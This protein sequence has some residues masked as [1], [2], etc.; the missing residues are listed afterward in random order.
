MFRD[1]VLGHIRIGSQPFGGTELKQTCD[2]D[3]SSGKKNWDKI[4]YI[5]KYASNLMTTAKKNPVLLSSTPNVVSKAQTKEFANLEKQAIQQGN[6]AKTK[7]AGASSALFGGVFAPKTPTVPLEELEQRRTLDEQMEVANDFA[8]L[9]DE[10]VDLDEVGDDTVKVSLG[11]PYVKEN[12]KRVR[13]SNLHET[14]PH[15]VAQC[16]NMVVSPTELEL[17][18]SLALLPDTFNSGT[19]PTKFKFSIVGQVIQQIKVLIGNHSNRNMQL[20]LEANQKSPNKANIL[21]NFANLQIFYFVVNADW[22]VSFYGIPVSSVYGYTQ[23]DR[24]ALI[25]SD[26]DASLWMVSGLHVYFTPEAISNIAGIDIQICKW[27]AYN[28][29]VC[30]FATMTD[31][32]NWTK[33]FEDE[34]AAKKIF[35]EIRVDAVTAMLAYSEKPIMLHPIHQTYMIDQN[36]GFKYVAKEQARVWDT[37]C[38]ARPYLGDKV[39]NVVM[40]VAPGIG[41]QMPDAILVA[42]DT[43]ACI[44]ACIFDAKLN[45][46]TVGNEDILTTRLSNL[47][48]AICLRNASHM[49][50]TGFRMQHVYNAAVTDALMHLN[51]FVRMHAK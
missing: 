32:H 49:R 4:D 24:A 36:S 10:I 14:S 48:T 9:N 33:V 13:Y 44:N 1:N 5:E 28:D 11:D 15:V 39:R 8:A 46:I 43:F 30:V 45:G 12:F 26:D 17:S 27:L 31:A 34:G 6:L 41:I 50:D 47:L 42:T 16:I 3:V 25:E 35:T 40:H 21:K 18:K 37:I 2:I 38:K 23:A 51:S 29:M 22:T 20:I 7:Q 19:V